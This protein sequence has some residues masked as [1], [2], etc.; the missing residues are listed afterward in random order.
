MTSQHYLAHFSRQSQQY[1]SYRPDYPTEL[2]A[3]LAT[4]VSAE[5]TVWDC[6]TGNGQAALSLAQYFKTIIAT[7]I[8]FQP[9][10]I[11]P[12]HNHIHYVCGLAEKACIKDNCIGLITIA[13]ALHWFNLPDFYAE[14][15]RVAQN[16]AIIAAWC[17]SLGSISPHVDR[18]IR[19]LYDEILI[20]DWPVERRYIDD[21]YTKIAFPFLP[22]TAPA[23]TIKKK[24][25]FARFIGYLNT[26]SA[27]KQYQQR[28]GKNPIDLVKNQLLAT[29]GSPDLQYT[30]Q[31]PIHILIG[32]VKELL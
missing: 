21:H 3:Y 14:V 6:G 31:W 1:F 22:L 17:Y 24:Y 15:R 11:A 5:N 28:V 20:A 29:W 4:L 32:K 13:Q 19:Q 7:D 25:N 12:K 26:W 23:M 27:V 16:N 10:Q 30:M 18:Y 8:H 2:F 9:L